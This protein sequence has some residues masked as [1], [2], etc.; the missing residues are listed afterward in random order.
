MTSESL[1][2][3]EHLCLCAAACTFCSGHPLIYFALQE[4]LQALHSTP[5]AFLSSP[6]TR[7]SLLLLQAD[8]NTPVL[9]VLESVADAGCRCFFT[10]SSTFLF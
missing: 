3:K 2:C 4:Q 8:L 9:Q 6:C 5:A 10:G 1:C 7:S